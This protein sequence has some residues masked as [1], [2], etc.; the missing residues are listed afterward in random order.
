M[1][2]LVGAGTDKVEIESAQF[3]LN[4][5]QRNASSKA[6]LIPATRPSIGPV[7]V[8]RLIFIKENGGGCAIQAIGT[9]AAK[10]IILNQ[11]E[12]PVEQ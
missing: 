11:N 9:L 10:Q 3:M 5:S 1:D 7:V 8:L 2:T 4:T 6:G 12:K